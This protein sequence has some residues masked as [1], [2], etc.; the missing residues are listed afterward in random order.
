MFRLR[1]GPIDYR[2]YKELAPGGAKRSGVEELIRLY[3]RD[4]LEHEL[5]LGIPGEEKPAFRLRGGAHA[6]QL[7]IDTWLHAEEPGFSWVGFPGDRRGSRS[8]RDRPVPKE[9]RAA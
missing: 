4:A 6:R 2:L 3:Q 7:G 8:E 5:L 1:I 9:G